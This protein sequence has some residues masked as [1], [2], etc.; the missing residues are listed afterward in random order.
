M[1]GGD[2]AKVDV[3]KHA[4]DFAARIA[5]GADNLFSQ[6]QPY[7]L[8]GLGSAPDRGGALRMLFNPNVPGMRVNDVVVARV[9]EHGLSPQEVVGFEREWKSLVAAHRQQLDGGRM[10][11]SRST[12]ENE[13]PITWS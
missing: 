7:A 11:T 6:S 8:P 1:A 4:T 10:S 3:I 9:G 5:I 13:P 12:D 2:P